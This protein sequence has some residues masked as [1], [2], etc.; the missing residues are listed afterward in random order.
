MIKGEGLTVLQARMKIIDP[1]DNETYKFLGVEQSDRMKNKDVME[2]MN[3]KLIRR[4]KL[5]TKTELNDKNLITA[6]NSKVIPVA[7]FT[8]N[9]CHFTKA[10]LSEL[11]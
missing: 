7:A 6:S 11:D 2:R 1:D 3:I 5:L 10:E 8:M 9:I 4:L